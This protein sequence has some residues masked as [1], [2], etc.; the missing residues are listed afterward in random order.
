MLADLAKDFGAGTYGDPENVGS[1]FEV[2]LDDCDDPIDDINAFVQLVKEGETPYF[3]L[4]ESFTERSR[5]IRCEGRLFLS[6][7]GVELA[8]NFP[9]KEGEPEF[10][11]RAMRIAGFQEDQI[12]AATELFFGEAPSPVAP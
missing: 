11:E 3:G 12:R 5:G 2:I 4:T 6:G 1:V 10:N 9:W 7:F 8:K